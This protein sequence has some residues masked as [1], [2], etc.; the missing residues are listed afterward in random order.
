M[1][2]NIKNLVKLITENPNL[3]VVPIVDSDLFCEDYSSCLGK[4]GNVYIDEIYY[5]DERYYLKSF[6]DEDLAEE[7]AENIVLDYQLN[8]DEIMDM[9]RK[10]VESYKWETVIVVNIDL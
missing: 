1:K 2:D 10:E 7:V 3:K 8:D 6:D 9:A 4:I 5:S